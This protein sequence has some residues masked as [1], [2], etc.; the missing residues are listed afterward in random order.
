MVVAAVVLYLLMRLLPLPDGLDRTGQSVLGVVLFGMVLWMSEVSPLGVT[1]LA[2]MVLLGTVPGLRPM[3]IFGGF[4]FPVV[5]FLIG[6]VGIAAAVEQTGLAHRAARRLL[7]GARGSPSRLYFQ[8][9]TSLPLLAVFV[10]SAITR[11]AILIPAYRESL[12]AIG[13]GAADG[14]ARALMLALGVLNPLASSAL[15][16]GG[17]ASMTAAAL[18]GEFSWLRWF[19]LMAIPYYAL[20]LLG[21]LILWFTAPRARQAVQAANRSETTENLR[22]AER[23][24]IAVL[25]LT[26]VLWLTDAWHGLTPAVP[27]LLAAILLVIP[28]LGVLTWKQL[29]ARLSWNL[30]LTVGASLSLANAIATSTAGSWLGQ[31]F[32]GTAL[33]LKTHPLAFIVALVVMVTVFHLA[34]TNLAACLALLI[35]IVTSTAAAAG[36]NPLVGGLI[37]TVA[38]DAVIL[39]PVQTATN[40]LAYETGYFSAAEV[41]RFG[42]LML[43]LTVGV[44]L[45]VAIP[46]WRLIGLSLAPG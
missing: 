20:L 30:I 13:L 35:P 22:P 40:L 34:I 27:A 38:V 43:G 29:E 21:G 6:A 15:L 14:R 2:V 10:P 24:T 17:I 44:V 31:I 7:A 1:A 4:A 33:E 32:A 46:Y 16:T 28:R 36:L 12:A 39:Y 19:A 9:L 23:W 18:L 41:R 37:V 11:N 42:L 3:Q 8:M 5:F 45:A 26:T 25:L